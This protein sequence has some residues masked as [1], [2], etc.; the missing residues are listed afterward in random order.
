[1][2]V[3]F[4]DTKTG[5]VAKSDYPFGIWWWAEG[6]GSCNCNRQSLFGIEGLDCDD[7]KDWDN[8]LQRFQAI[9]VEDH[10]EMSVVQQLEEV[11]DGVREDLILKTKEDILKAINHGLY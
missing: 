3:T 9:D 10:P 4:K 6:N 1:M 11:N 5:A 7:D 8:D 2:I